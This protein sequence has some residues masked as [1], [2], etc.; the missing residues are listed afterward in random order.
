MDIETKIELIKRPPT[1]EVINDDDLRQLFETKD[2]P[3]A[4][5]GF[6][7]SGP[8]HLGTGLISAFKIKDFIEAG[9]HYKVLL[10]DWHAYL[11]KKM[12]GD[13]AKIKKVAEYFK[14]GWEALGVKNVEY[15]YAEELI[16]RKEYWEMVMN[17]STK[18]TLKRFQRCLP[19]LGR[20]EQSGLTFGQLLYPA[21][22]CADIFMLKVDINQL[23]MDQRNVNMLAREVGPKLGLW[24]PVAVHHHLL[25]GL[26]KQE[27]M[28]YDVDV[29]LDAQISSKASKSIPDSAIFITDNP[30]EIRRKINKAYCPEKALVENPIYEI[31]KYIILREK[32]AAFE[33]IRKEQHG[34]NIIL[35]LNE[36]EEQYSKGEVHPQDVKKSVAEKLIEILE[37]ARTYFKN[38]KKFLSVF[39]AAKITR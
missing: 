38:N 18:T 35:T 34:G 32:D 26:I 31:V 25:M 30:D 19:I 36:F 8:M 4:Y 3:I 20:T 28:G 5:N 1:E 39:K 2:H 7:P 33:I 15:I 14:A 12:G 9:V 21:L 23:G 16:S 17:I 22:Q 29:N 11:N 13:M 27:R 6:E 10:A 37:P 24:K